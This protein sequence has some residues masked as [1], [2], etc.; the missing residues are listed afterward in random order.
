[1]MAGYESNQGD[2]QVVE[3]GPFVIAL[4][5]EIVKS[6]PSNISLQGTLMSSSVLAHGLISKEYFLRVLHTLSSRQDTA[7][8]T[9]AESGYSPSSTSGN[10]RLQQQLD[11][12]DERIKELSDENAMLRAALAN[13][14]HPNRHTELPQVAV[15]SAQADTT[16]EGKFTVDCIP[17]LL[18][19]NSTTTAQICLSGTHVASALPSQRLKSTRTLLARDLVQLYDDLLREFTMSLDA[20]SHEQMM[21]STTK[22]EHI[23]YLTTL[24]A[25]LKHLL[26]QLDSKLD[27]NRRLFEGYAFILVAVVGRQL[28]PAVFG[29]ARGISVEAE[30][31][32]SELM[33]EEGTQHDMSTAAPQLRHL[34][35]L[36]KH[37]IDKTSAFL[38]ASDQTVSVL[39]ARLQHT[40]VEAIFGQGDMPLPV[41]TL[42]LPPI[43]VHSEE[44]KSTKLNVTVSEWF[45]QEVWSI[46]GWDVIAQL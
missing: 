28:Y 10:H 24:T 3:L 45:V 19:V 43:T 6:R 41:Q 5:A 27:S 17:S 37:T 4:A 22:H 33:A 2:A 13:S 29:H 34:L 9:G 7:V 25:F 31:R 35:S 39:R 40:L 23:G 46:I 14:S 12:R 20:P 8:S 11:G 21:D 26:D 15:Q 42:Q 30:I 36:L 38:D 32:A 44:A 16:S 1:M 18:T